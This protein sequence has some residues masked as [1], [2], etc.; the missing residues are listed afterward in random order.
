MAKECYIWLMS[1]DFLVCIG[2]GNT[3]CGNK[4]DDTEWTIKIVKVQ[5]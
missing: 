3:E 2:T 1:E 5:L 4:V